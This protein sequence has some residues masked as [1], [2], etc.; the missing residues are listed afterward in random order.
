MSST[1]EL[2]KSLRKWLQDANLASHSIDSLI[3]NGYN[4]IDAFICSSEDD[5][6]Q[7]ANNLN[8]PRLDKLQLKLAIKKYKNNN[9]TAKI[10]NTSTIPSPQ[11]VQV[12]SSNHEQS[13]GCI[14]VKFYF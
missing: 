11:H 10:S 13:Y 5:I 9:N 8:I 6:E 1:N 12:S 4:E 7:I 2:T 3:S 14:H